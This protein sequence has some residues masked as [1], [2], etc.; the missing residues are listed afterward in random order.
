MERLQ[1][2]EDVCVLVAEDGNYRLEKLFRSKA[3]LYVGSLDAAQV[4][5]L[6]AMLAADTLAT[7]S[8]ADIHHPLVTDTLDRLELAAWRADRWQELKFFSADSRKPFRASLDPLLRWFQNVQKERPQASRLEGT[9]S[10]CVPPATAQLSASG[11]SLEIRRGAPAA[12]N[13]A[14]LFRFYSRHFYR[15]EVEGSC[16][17]V[18]ADGG[19]RR[20]HTNQDIGADRRDKVKE[21]Q[22]SEKELQELKTILGSTDLRS[23]PGNPGVGKE[24][25]SQEGARTILNVPREGMVQNLV[26]STSF[27]T[28]GRPNEIGGRSNLTYTT[29][30]EKVLDPLKRWIKLNVDHDHTPER[31]ELGNDCSPVA[32]ASSSDTGATR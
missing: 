29:A 30:D 27:N 4:E 15:G 7:M 8:Q 21:G 1:P 9:P 10:R 23:S 16:T 32:K 12:S 19:Y 20:E 13:T 22:I 25:F 24:Q 5:E 31:G 2:G 26:F 28:I 11:A 6:H 17:I 3:E 14:Y 18:F